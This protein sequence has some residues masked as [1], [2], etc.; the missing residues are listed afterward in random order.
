[1]SPLITV[2]TATF[3]RVH[4]LPRLHASLASQDFRDF[5][6]LIMDDG[7][8]DGTKVLVESFL[9]RGDMDIHYELLTNGGKHRAINRGALLARGQAFF[10]VDSDDALP[11]GALSAIARAW[12]GVEADPDCCGLMGYKARFEGGLLSSSFPAGLARAT[13]LELKYYKG[14][15][16]DKAEVL[17]T[18]VQRDYPFPEIPGESFITEDSVFN[19]IA[20]AK[21][22]LL[23]P[24]VLYL[25]DYLP[26]GLTARSLELRTRNPRGALLY[27]R[28]LRGAAVPAWIRLRAGANFYRIY[29]LQVPALREALKGELD[30]AR[31]DL[32]SR[33]LGRLL[34][35]RDRLAK[36]RQGKAEA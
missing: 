6:W 22:F 17:C 15:K 25:G 30:R 9:A 35:L 23:L 18:Q 1:M 3:N 14:V 20:A 36:R 31:L 33:T 16:G 19:R 32:A 13:S 26:G 27:Y 34:F 5:E 28:E 12:P 11:E 29:L 10:V 8:R 4:T 21:A 2:C 7:S 24:Q